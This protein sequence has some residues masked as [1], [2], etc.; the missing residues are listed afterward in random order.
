MSTADSTLPSTTAVTESNSLSQRLLR[1]FAHLLSVLFHPLFIPTYVFL[2]LMQV[3]PYEFAGITPWQLTLRLFSAFWWTAFVP[4][5][6]IF[7]LW[8]LQF[9]NSILLLTRKERIVPFII[10]M[11]FDWWQYYLSRHFDNQPSVLRFFY[12]GI[13]LS[14]VVGLILNS[15]LKISLHGIAAG[16]A[17]A[18]VILF[19]WYYGLPLW[20]YI[21]VTTL[22]AG[23][24]ASARLLISDHSSREVYIGLLTGILCQLFAYF[25]AA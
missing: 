22:L 17:V 12:L 6:A 24:V 10:V 4:A 16:G 25:F 14:T 21:L 9:I 20:I 11:F 1:L 7:L 8:R 3:V 18:A 13:F 19:S 5:F 15:Y 23:L 2:L